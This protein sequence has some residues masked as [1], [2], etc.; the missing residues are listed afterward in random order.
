MDNRSIIEQCAAGDK[1]AMAALYRRYAPK[2]MRLIHRYVSDEA[3]AEDILHD[4]FVVV[5]THMEEVRQ[6]DRL[7]YW[8]GTIM[9]NLSLNY[10]SRIDLTTV[11][12]EDMELPEVP[13]LEEILT[14]EELEEIVNR[15]PDGYRNI[16][17][18]AVLEHKSHKEIGRLLGI[19]P[20]SSSSQLYHAKVLLRKMI[21]E[22]KSGA[23]IVLLLCALAGWW[24]LSPHSRRDSLDMPDTPHVRIAAEAPAVAADTAKN[25][26]SA[27][28]VTPVEYVRRHTAEAVEKP[29]IA[30]ALVPVHADTLPSVEEATQPAPQNEPAPETPRKEPLTEPVTT[31]LPMPPKKHTGWNVGAIYGLN[32]KLPDLRDSRDGLVSD[33]NPGPKPPPEIVEDIARSRRNVS[34]EMPITV[35]IAVSRQLTDRLSLESGISYTLLRTGIDYTGKKFE[36]AQRYRT[37]YIGVPLKLNC[38]L[39][40][41]SRF[42]LYAAAGAA[43]DI[44]V[45]NSLSTS[46][47]KGNVE[48]YML[49]SLSARTQFSLSFGLGLQYSITPTVGLFA[50]PGI[51][52]NFNNRSALPTYWQENSTAFNLPIG[53]RLSW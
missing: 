2:M 53:L 15:L 23:V 37:S 3:A 46:V 7:E 34:H 22:K 31:A 21:L 17:K 14:Y 41:K 39:V 11:L 33:N 30:E 36:A 27:D 26:E 28:T 12:D 38:R 24:L 18:L 6:P 51:R 5:F 20:H 32:G 13:E 16:F 19:A 47:T 49:P 44:P 35:G 45:V 9:K 40:G 48:P 29:A 1:S 50:E 25:R 8:M 10:L 43:V 4:G 52:Y 42:S